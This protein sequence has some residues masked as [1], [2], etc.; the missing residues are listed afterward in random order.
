MA[1]KRSSSS[2]SSPSTST[3]L[4]DQTQ[5]SIKL[6]QDTT[7]KYCIIGAGPAGMSGAKALKDNDIPFDGFETYTEQKLQECKGR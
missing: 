1:N 2:I 4:S 3:S 6:P 7:E 5:A